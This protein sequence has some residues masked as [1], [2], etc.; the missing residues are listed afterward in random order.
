MSQAKWF[1]GESRVFYRGDE[2]ISN[3][4]AAKEKRC[5][6]KR[7]R[8]SLQNTAQQL[9]LAF[10]KTEDISDDVIVLKKQ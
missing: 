1:D 5:L 9:K 2:V 3:K 6:S 7:A 8:K 10:S 4:S